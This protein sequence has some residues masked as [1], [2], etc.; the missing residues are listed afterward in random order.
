VT[1]FFHLVFVDHTNL[2]R[3]FELIYIHS[4]LA[5]LVGGL[6]GWGTTWSGCPHEACEERPNWMQ[7]IPMGCVHVTRSALEE[8]P[9]LV[10][11]VQVFKIL[12]NVH[13]GYVFTC[14]THLCSFCTFDN[15]A[16]T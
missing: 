9:V 2:C 11:I 12:K 3:P 5:P 4:F 16:S 6:G 13:H 7:T 8:R 15:C 10:R 14:S 1:C